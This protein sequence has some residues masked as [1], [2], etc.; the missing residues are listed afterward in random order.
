MDTTDRGRTPGAQPRD[1]ATA[2]PLLA[3]LLLDLS[4]AELVLLGSGQLLKV[5]PLTLRMC[6]F[7]A[8]L[9]YAAIHG[10]QRR[11][12]DA[13]LGLLVLV[14]GVI[15]ALGALVGLVLG[16]PL[17]QVGEDVKPLAFFLGIAFF[18][19]TIRTT[20]DVERVAMIVRRCSVLLGIGYLALLVAVAAG[21]IPFGTVYTLLSESG[22]VFFRGEQGFFYKGFIYLGIGICF[23]AFRRGWI[24]R[25]P[26]LFLFGALTLTLTRGLILTT[27]LVVGLA[28]LVRQRNAVKSLLG[29]TAL[30]A[31]AAGVAPLVVELVGDRASSDAIRLID[32]RNVAEGVT[33][34]SIWVGHGLG[35]SIGMRPR[36]ESTYVEFIHKQ[37]L[38]GFV[39]WGLLFGLLVRDFLRSRRTGLADTA[40]PFFL[41]AVFVYLQTATNPFLTNPIGMSFVLV[42]VVSLRVLANA[43]VP[44]SRTAAADG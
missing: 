43:G 15:T 40:L 26:A 17:A 31:A 27:A 25:L 7:A 5:G 11:R 29:T 35:A 9:T 3:R 16:A 36:I 44:P 38:V 22:E 4:L 34:W 6:L 39:V 23:F 32:L 14:F 42:A 24:A 12:F 10:L 21:V 33:W 41:G 30:A 1:P 28:L 19:S 2:P 20:A 8:G 13:E 37:G 18:A